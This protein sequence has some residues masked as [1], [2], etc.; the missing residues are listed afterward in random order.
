MSRAWFGKNPAPLT[1][2]PTVR[3][4]KT[5]S[6]QSGYVYQYH[7]EGRRGSGQGTEFV[8]H[9]SADRKTWQHVSVLLSERAA[10]MWE[11]SH[12][13]TL[14]SS[15]RYALAKLALFAAFD[16]RATPAAMNE[17]VQVG[18]ALLAE[19]ADRLGLD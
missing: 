16:E 15:E 3:R 4:V 18:D 19:F 17:P 6:A 1:G 12:G 5:W 14:S 10:G 7:Y 9:V 11:Q 2:A 8:F 13:R